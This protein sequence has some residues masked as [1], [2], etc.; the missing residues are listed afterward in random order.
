[1]TPFAPGVLC[2]TIPPAAHPDQLCVLVRRVSSQ[3]AIHIMKGLY[4]QSSPCVEPRFARAKLWLLDRNIQGRFGIKMP[5]ATEEILRPLH[6][7]G[8]LDE[9]REDQEVEA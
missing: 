4:P 2:I 9:V 6:G 7:P 1:M 8:V 3:E 5:I